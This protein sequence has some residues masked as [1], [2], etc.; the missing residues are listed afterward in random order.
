LLHPDV[1]PPDL[2]NLVIDCMRAYGAT[3]LG[4]VANVEPAHPTGRDILGF[5]SYGYAQAL[6]RLD[7]VEEYLLFLYSHRFHDHSRG[8]WMAGEV[9]G[10]TGDTTLFCIPAQQTIPLLVRWMLVLEDSD[11]ERLYF[12]K[13][14]PREWVASGKE[15]RI[16][17]APT[18]FGRV[19]FK[20]IS[21]GARR[22]TATVVLPRQGGPKEIEVKLRLPTKHAM[23]SVTVNGRPAT[24]GGAHRDSVVIPVDKESRFEVVGEFA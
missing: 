2:A 10:I 5:I 19:D 17:Q 15:I 11:E 1:L 20:M 18:R 4:V 9:S 13:G 16:D 22:V 3:T 12:G 6:L 8:S 14:L 21:D 23:K 7:R 24:P